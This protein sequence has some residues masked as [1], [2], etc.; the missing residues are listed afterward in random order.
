MFHLTTLRITDY[1][2]LHV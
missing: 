2:G 1:E